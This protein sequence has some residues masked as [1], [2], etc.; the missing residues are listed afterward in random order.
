[1]NIKLSKISTTTFRISWDFVLNLLSQPNPKLLKNLIE[2]LFQNFRL[3]DLKW[4]LRD[5]SENL[6]FLT[7]KASNIELDWAI[8]ESETNFVWFAIWVAFFAL[9]PFMPWF[10][11]F[12]D[13]NFFTAADKRGYKPKLSK[14]G[15]GDTYFCSF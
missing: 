4:L 14:T 12:K 11:F 3:Q 10:H 9:N 6:K 15:P 13:F 2:N 1:M 7:P 5:F 8:R